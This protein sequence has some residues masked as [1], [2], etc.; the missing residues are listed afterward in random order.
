MVRRGISP[1][2]IVSCSVDESGIINLMAQG[3]KR[4]TKSDSAGKKE[5]PKTISIKRFVITY[6][7]LMLAFFFVAWFKPI[8]NIIDV[9][10]VYTKSVVVLSSKILRLTGVSCT[11]QGSIIA[12]PALSLD[13]KFGCN[14]LEAVMIYAIA[15]VAY[16]AHWKKKLVG[17]AAGFLVLQAAN[18]LRILLLAYSGIHLKGLFQFIHVYIAQG[19]MIALA[20][21]VFFLYLNYAKKVETAH[22]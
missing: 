13:V 6:I 3:R 15:V 20:L 22:N 10:D 4:N 2:L 18:I 19:I 1:R 7:A 5:K 9:N 11:Y 12:L 8:H 14:G 16:P 17:I 21:A